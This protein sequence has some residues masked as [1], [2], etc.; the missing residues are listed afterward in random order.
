MKD[1]HGKEIKTGMNV[2]MPEPNET[3]I[4]N[5]GGF[6][7]YVEELAE[8]NNTIVVSDGD[9]DFFQLEPDR[10]EIVL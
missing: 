10:V 3:D 4:W 8:Y 1:K 5:F 2:M 7:A 9:G 6:V